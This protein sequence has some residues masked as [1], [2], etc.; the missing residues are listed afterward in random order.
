MVR[1]PVQLTASLTLY[2]K[3]G[4]LEPEVITIRFAGWTSGRIGSFQQRTDIPKL[5]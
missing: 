2:W 5:L 1:A 4:L 3:A